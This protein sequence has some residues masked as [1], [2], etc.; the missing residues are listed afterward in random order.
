[1]MTDDDVKRLDADT[2]HA[3]PG[4]AVDKQGVG[5]A[6]TESTDTEEN[7]DPKS[8]GTPVHPAPSEDVES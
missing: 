4:D 6:P 1:M 5:Q 7:Q 8:G 3:E 2:P